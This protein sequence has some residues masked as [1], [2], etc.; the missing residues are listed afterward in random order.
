MVSNFSAYFTTEANPHFAR[1]ERVIN[2]LSEDKDSEV[3]AFF[4]IPQAYD[5]DGEPIGDISVSY[6]KF[7]GKWYDERFS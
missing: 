7:P 4:E 1:M 6:K 5:S 2:E 3:K